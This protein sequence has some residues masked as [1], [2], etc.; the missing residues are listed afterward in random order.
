MLPFPILSFPHS[1]HP[2]SLIFQSLVHPLFAIAVTSTLLHPAIHQFQIKKRNFAKMQFATSFLLGASFIG[3]ALAQSQIAFTTLPSAVQAGVPF[4]LKWGGGQPNVSLQMLQRITTTSQLTRMLSATRDSD[5]QKRH[6]RKSPIRRHDRRY[7]SHHDSSSLRNRS[8]ARPAHTSLG[9]ATGTSYDWTP[10]KSLTDGQYALEIAQG[11]DSI[12]YSGQF[13]LSGGLPATGVISSS[14]SSST[15]SS[16][17]ISSS[18]SSS[19]SSG[20]TPIV[21]IPVPVPQGGS[22]NTLVTTTTSAGNA[23]VSITTQLPGT[24]VFASGA[25]GAGGSIATGTV[26]DRNTTMSSATLKSTSASSTGPSSTSAGTTTGAST[27]STQR[28][29]STP[30][31]AAMRLGSPI[32]LILGVFAAVVYLG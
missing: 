29:S 11:L 31:G 21:P 23:T 10:S 32:A 7:T 9:R 24:G 2:L 12:N 15:M 17:T 6:I 22:N 14:A 26:M 27:S 4:T 8:F 1:N 3:A 5:A 20:I 16:S 30:T 25:S 18:T 28:P 13:T 19:A